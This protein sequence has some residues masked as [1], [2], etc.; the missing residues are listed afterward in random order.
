MYGCFKAVARDF[1]GDGRLDIAAISFFADYAAHPEESFL[2][3]HGTGDFQFQAYKVPGTSGGRWLTM[4]TGDVDG[5]GREDIV[6]GNFSLA[7]PTVESAPLWKN[8]PPFILLKNNMK[9]K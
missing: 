8:G 1:D 7:P 5:D 2:Y 4:D 6:L 9:R 3:F